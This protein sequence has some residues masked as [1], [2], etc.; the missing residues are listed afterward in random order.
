M[1]NL[2]RLNILLKEALAKSIKLNER[3][4]MFTIEILKKNDD[5]ERKITTKITEK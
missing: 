3:R 5:A 4:A 1:S 2:P